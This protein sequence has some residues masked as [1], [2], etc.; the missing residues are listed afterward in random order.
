MNN[1]N[2]RSKRNASTGPTTLISQGCKLEGILTGKGKFMIDGDVEGECNVDGTITLA[3][4]GHCSGVIQ[5]TDVIIAGTV[6]GDIIA[7]GQIEI[8]NTA[9]ITGSVFGAAISVQEG[10]VIEGIMTT[11]AQKAS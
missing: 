2:D 7:T 8:G 11:S 4:G 10:A 1:S 5:A 6:D 3:R 9:K